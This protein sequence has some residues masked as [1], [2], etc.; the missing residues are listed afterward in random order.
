[1]REQVSNFLVKYFHYFFE[2]MNLSNEFGEYVQFW[3]IFSGNRGNSD[4]DPHGIH[5]K[6]GV[7]NQTDQY[8]VAIYIEKL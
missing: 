4:V 8:I 3:I 5:I 2:W 7:M 1:M 6:N